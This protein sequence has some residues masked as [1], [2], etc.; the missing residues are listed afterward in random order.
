MGHASGMS[1]TFFLDDLFDLPDDTTEQMPGMIVGSLFV[2]LL[3]IQLRLVDGR[4][5]RSR[6]AV[7]ADGGARGARCRNWRHA[8]REDYQPA[9]Q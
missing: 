3:E 6:V 5:E 4:D 1:N 8:I 2:W 7:V 9:W